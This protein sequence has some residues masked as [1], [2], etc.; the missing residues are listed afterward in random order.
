GAQQLHPVDVLRLPRDVYRAHVDD[1]LHA[2]A[3]RHRRGGHA[4]LAGAGL[5][6]HARLAHPLRE[7]CLA[8]RVVDLVCAGVVQV[9]ALEPDLRAA[10]HLRPAL[11]VI[12]GARATDEVLELV[13]ELGD[14]LRV[15]AV[16]L[17]GDAQFLER[18]HEG[19]CD[20]DAPIGA[21]VAPGIRK[22]VRLHRESCCAESARSTSAT[23]RSMR[24]RDFARGSGFGPPTW[25]PVDTSTIVGRTRAMAVATF[26]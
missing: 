26:S 17:V 13:L 9:F 10:E 19:L 16:A 22:I 14:E 18:V 4:V 8:D 2:V 23:N 25:M 21:E 3:G 12:D 24:S 11:R 15:A 7:Q 20:E 1:A 6:D 5:G